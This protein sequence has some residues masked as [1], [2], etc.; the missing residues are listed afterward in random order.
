LIAAGTVTA[1]K[2]RRTAFKRD[3]RGMHS[4]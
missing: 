4:T 2:L 1:G 3:V